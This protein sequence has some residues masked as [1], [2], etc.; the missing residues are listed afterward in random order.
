MR[1]RIS[2]QILRTI[3][4]PFFLFCPC[5]T[6]SILSNALFHY[7][8][9]CLIDDDFYDDL[10][11]GVEEFEYDDLAEDDFRLIKLLRAQ[12]GSVELQ[13][14]SFSLSSAPP[15]DALSYKWETESELRKSRVI[16]NGRCF[17]LSP[18][19]HVALHRIYLLQS[20]VKHGTEY[21]MYLWNDFTCINQRNIKERE[22][23]VLK[24]ADI[25]AGAQRAIVWLGP[26][27][28]LSNLALLSIPGII[29]RLSEHEGLVPK[30]R[31]ETAGLENMALWEAYGEFF[32][33]PWFERLWVLQ[34][35]V[36]AS[37]I[38]LIC[39]EIVVDWAVLSDLV[40]A[41]ANAGLLPTSLREARLG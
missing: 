10:D 32:H 29:E 8:F 21:I 4:T 36:L 12:T 3:I 11:P 23:Q 7:A 31:L 19:L 20:L 37:Q 30:T 35:A 22:V 27:D 13:L 34:E 15:Y 26:A 39:G 14:E 1:P 9:I 24:M 33:K 5:H 40:R 17:M 2:D 41:F 6:A 38:T 28:R 16:C 25:Y 18:D